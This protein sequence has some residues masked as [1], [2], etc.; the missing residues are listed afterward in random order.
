MADEADHPWVAPLK[1]A[2]TA[3]AL[4]QVAEPIMH[5]GGPLALW[6]Q[7][8]VQPSTQM[9]TYITPPSGNNPSSAND[10]AGA[11]RKWLLTVPA[12]QLRGVPAAPAPGLQDPDAEMYA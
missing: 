9:Q 2:D 3:V 8:I 6:L 12:A 5:T 1:L 10:M 4:A 11:M 7:T